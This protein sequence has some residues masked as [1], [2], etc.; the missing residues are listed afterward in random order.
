MAF[1]VYETSSFGPCHTSRVCRCIDI[2]R[3]RH[4]ILRTFAP[5]ETWRLCYVYDIEPLLC[6]DIE[7]FSP[8]RT[9]SLSDV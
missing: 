3:F 8:F 1:A 6:K 4:I 5:Y 2:E 7:A 9:T